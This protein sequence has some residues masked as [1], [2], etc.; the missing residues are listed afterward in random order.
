MFGGQKS[1]QTDSASL[2]AAIRVQW[3]ERPSNSSMRT[4]ITVCCAE[5]PGSNVETVRTILKRYK[6]T[7][8]QFNP[9]CK[10]DILDEASL[11]G[12]VCVLQRRGAP[13][14]KKDILNMAETMLSETGFR[15]TNSWLDGFLFRWNKLLARAKESPMEIERLATLTEPQ[16][17][18]FIQS[19]DRIKRHIL[20]DGSNLVNADEVPVGQ[21]SAS[22]A[23][24]WAAMGRPKVGSLVEKSENLRTLIPFLS[25]TGKVLMVVLVY[26]FPKKE[27]KIQIHIPDTFMNRRH[28]PFE[29]YICTAPKGFVNLELWKAIM[30]RWAS[31]SNALFAQKGSVL[32]CDNLACHVN[33]EVVQ[34]CLDSQVYIWTIPPHTSH[35]LQPNDNGSNAAIKKGVAERK[36]TENI[37]TV[38]ANLKPSRIVSVVLLQSIEQCLTEAVV[39]RSW[40]TTGIWPWNPKT[41]RQECQPYLKP[42]E[43]SSSTG[44]TPSP[45]ERITSQYHKL[46]EQQSPQKVVVVTQTDPRPHCHL[47][48]DI[49]ASGTALSEIRLAKQQRQ[50]RLQIA[51]QEKAKRLAD[52]SAERLERKAGR[53][54]RKRK[55]EVD[56]NLKSQHFS[57]FACKTTRTK[58]VDWMTCTCEGAGGLCP[59]CFWLPTEAS[60]VKPVCRICKNDLFQSCRFPPVMPKTL[61]RQVLTPNPTSSSSMDTDQ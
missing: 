19:F 8:Q 26:V 55:K 9:T 22:S 36:S 24:V 35:F 18:A 52:D 12:L 3:T 54:A 57:C 39:K 41:I 53:E 38:L 47:Y 20:K 51:R 42:T 59:E 15:P 44:Q 23:K 6:K 28:K 27:T 25:A 32:L 29:V 11:A 46:I 37:A 61:A 33:P 5:E 16:I 7:I 50:E 10:V 58:G 30:K 2:K 31:T 56:E 40:E 48:E 1:E 14:R 60:G 21:Y 43:N 13:P 4:H 17:E 45:M 34:S 49:I